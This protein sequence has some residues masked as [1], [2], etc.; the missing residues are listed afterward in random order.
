MSLLRGIRRG[1]KASPHITNRGIKPH[2]ENPPMKV[3]LKW[4]E[5]YVPLTMPPARLVERL[6]LA[7]LDKAMKELAR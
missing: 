6:T 3:P 7:G 5:E 2:R 1:P 4:L